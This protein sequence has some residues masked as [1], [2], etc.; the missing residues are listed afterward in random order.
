MFPRHLRILSGSVALLAACAASPLF[1]GSPRVTHVH[2]AAG[3]RG[4]EI[5]IECRGNNLSDAV[6]MLF[7]EPGLE[8]ASLKAEGGKVT[9][10]VKVAPDVRIG[11]HTFRVITA[12]GVSDLRLFYVSPFPMVAEVEPKKE[13]A[14]KPQPIALG[15][16]VYGR[17]PQDDRDYYEVEAKKGQRISIEVIGSRLQSQDI[18]DAA[19]TVANPA[20]EIIALSD[21]SAFNRQDP[22]LSVV[23]PEDGKYVI[24]IRESTNLGAGQAAY[25]MNVGSFPRPLAVYPPGGKAGEEV[26]LRLISETAGVLEKTVKLP[27]EPNERFAVLPEDQQ[28][29]PTP[30]FI[31]VSA[32][33]NVLEAEP[34]NEHTVATAASQELP[35]AFNGIIETP[36][37]VD[38]FKFT[39]KKGQAYDI[40]VFARQLRSP[41]D[42]ILEMYD[43]RGKKAQ[44]NDDSGGMDSY[45]RWSAPADG[46]F[47]LSV[48]DQLGRG[49]PLFTYRVEVKSVQPNVHMWLPE[50]VQNSSQERRAIVTPKGN[51]Y[52]TLLRVKRNDVGGALTFAPADLPEGMTATIPQMDKSVDTIPV[53]FEASGEA[54]PGA[55]LIDLAAKLAEQPAEGAAPAPTPATRI[56]HEVD[57]AE[58]GNQRAFYGVVEDRLP[59]AIVEEAPLLLTLEEPKTPILQ[60]GSMELKVK[61]ERKGNFKGPI[62]LSLLYAPP[63]IGTPGNV[64]I[65]EGENEGKLS[66]SANDKAQIMK[67][68]I[69]VVGGADFGKGQVFLS[70]QLADLEVAAGFVA[71]KI[72]R[73]FVDQGATSEIT[74]KLEQKTPFE[75]KAKIALMG[76]PE[77]VTAEEQEVTKDDKEVKFTLKA[78]P[79]AQVGAHKTLFCQF[80]LPQNGG[81]MINSF[82]QGGVLRVDRAS[83]ASK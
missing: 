7:D 44:S 13:E 30:N 15:T 24:C 10:K 17:T 12:S 50:M 34:N 49:G 46:D 23:A 29:A 80:K 26:K 57:M 65:K 40:G 48:K 32:F 82:A 52:A 4:A 27:E 42:S 38:F 62:T 56:R 76:L 31:R 66:I 16:T 18:Y 69:C 21:D 70:T 45:L 19:V 8:M 75:G 71:G 54:K 22:V 79:T 2:P 5:E 9:A 51:R 43:A 59:A 36:G 63:G 20:G 39:A 33:P 3:Q 78:T 47:Y 60:N 1:A 81:E 11:E 41:L 35:L 73:S 58:N 61:A 77:G 25:V 72:D 53:L 28:T 37:D 67:W 64:Q 83:L 14:T 55:K 68:K 74:V 6:G